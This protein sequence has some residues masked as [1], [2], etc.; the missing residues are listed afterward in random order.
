MY[1]HCRVTENKDI[2]THN[3]ITDHVMNIDSMFDKHENR[4][5]YKLHEPTSTQRTVD[6]FLHIQFF[7]FN[8]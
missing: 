6:S 8:Q 5:D 4:N 7:F 3:F 1:R 2:K